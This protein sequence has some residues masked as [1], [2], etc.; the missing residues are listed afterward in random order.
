VI[1]RILRRMQL[2]ET[3]FEDID[4]VA[5]LFNNG[6][7]SRVTIRGEVFAEM[8]A[9][10]L[11]F[12]ADRSVKLRGRLPVPGKCRVSA[13]NL[14]L[15]ASVLSRGK[16]HSQVGKKRN[17]AFIDRSRISGE[18]V[19]DRVR[20]GVRFHPYGRPGRK[21]IGDFLTDIK[22]P[23]PLR[24]ELPV[25]YDADGVVWISGIEIDN[26]VAITDSTEEVVRLAIRHYT[27]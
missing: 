5:E 13:A 21:K 1:Q 19:V 25:V 3:T 18:L 20:N 27:D 9:G 26:R 24:D 22:F 14:E 6:R 11:Y 2:S 4:R 10:S 12:Y 7:K 8:A 15:T 17:L 23:R 16:V